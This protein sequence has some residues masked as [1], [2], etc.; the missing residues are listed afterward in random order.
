VLIAAC[1]AA[2]FFIINN[3]SF[4]PSLVSSSAKT[5]EAKQK[6]EKERSTKREKES[7]A[8]IPTKSSAMRSHATTNL[9]ANSVKSAGTT[10]E[11]GVT[12]DVEVVS[13]RSHA[14]VK[15]DDTPVYSVNS[16]ESSIVKLLNKGDWVSTDLDVIDVNGRWTIVKK[17]DLSKPG[18]V[19][20]ENLQPANATK[21]K[22]N[23][24]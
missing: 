21:R 18:F 1:L 14:T 12:D 17:S 19:Q 8:R 2:T 20:P 3:S 15:G 4:R 16:K 13:D 7:R 9:T 5:E 24:K 6:S 11:P 22:E 23:R 10:K